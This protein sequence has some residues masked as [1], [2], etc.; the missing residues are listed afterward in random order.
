M[1]NK[2]G[3]QE[4]CQYCSS[5][6]HQ[7]DLVEKATTVETDIEGHLMGVVLTLFNRLKYGGLIALLMQ[8]DLII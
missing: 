1:S 7:G 2:A 3:S 5:L 6:V 8:A 4:K